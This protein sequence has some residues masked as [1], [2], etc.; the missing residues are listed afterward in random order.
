MMKTF[1]GQLLKLLGW[2]ITGQFPDIKKAILIFA[3]H[4]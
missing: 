4:K 3:P 2:K 1:S